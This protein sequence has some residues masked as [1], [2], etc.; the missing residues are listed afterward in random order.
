M[1]HL[2]GIFSFSNNK[3]LHLRLKSSLP[4]PAI[5]SSEANNI[6]RCVTLLTFTRKC[7]SRRYI[8][9]GVL[10]CSEG[11]GGLLKQCTVCPA[12]A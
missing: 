2:H 10:A 5:P 9:F 12:A 3:T 11:W 4:P 7:T 1:L 8:T 6:S